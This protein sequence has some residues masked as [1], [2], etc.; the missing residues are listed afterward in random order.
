MTRQLRILALI[1]VVL[2]V[3]LGGCA[4]QS[5]RFWDASAITSQ[6]GSTVT[7]K[8]PDDARGTEVQI[9]RVR[10]IEEVK[11][12]VELAARIRAKLMISHATEPNA[13]AFTHEGQPVVAITAGMISLLGYDADA[14]AVILG[15]EYGHLAHKHVEAREQRTALRTTTSAVLGFIL[16]GVTPFGGTLVDLGAV[17]VETAYSRDEEREAD[18]EGFDYAV[19]AGYDPRGAVR[20]WGKMQAASSGFSIPFLSTHPVSQERIETMEALIAALPT[21]ND[22]G[23]VAVPSPTPASKPIDPSIREQIALG[24]TVYG[25][26]DLVA[27]H[28]LPHEDADSVASVSR[29]SGLL[30]NEVREEW[31]RVQS[32]AGATGW[33]RRDSVRLV[34]D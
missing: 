8:G 4:T 28:D 6:L 20:L 31:I 24:K 29:Y 11:D 22:A 5:P 19:R 33:I 25:S 16:G 23:A 1:P 18:R 12:R 7:L 3:L 10:L 2:L 34:L 30:V 9:G 32:P 13:Y 21:S 17:A 14:Y 15:H 27:I 26:T